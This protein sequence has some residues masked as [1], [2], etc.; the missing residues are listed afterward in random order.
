MTTL[1]THTIRDATAADRA[2]LISVARDTGLFDERELA[3]FSGMI[4][5]Y[6][7]GD[8]EDHAWLVV[9]DDGVVVGAA[10]YAPEPMTRGVW[11]LY[12]IGLRPSHQG[13]GRGAA[14][15]AR[16]ER[17]LRRRGQRVLL[18]ETSGT[19]GFE[20]T[21]AFYRKNGYAE[22]ARIRDYY[23]PGDDKFVFW[24]ALEDGA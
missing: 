6:F 11:N 5:A 3:E 17:A 14:L 18:V 12:F 7:A 21:R 24:K 15:L 1:E 16:V 20:A 4:A 13:G 9:D 8:L 19:S 22:E 10:Y 23:A 2:A